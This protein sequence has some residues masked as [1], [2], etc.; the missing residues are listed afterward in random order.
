MRVNEKQKSVQL[1][2]KKTKKIPSSVP[3]AIDSPSLDFNI[4]AIIAAE[5]AIAASAMGTNTNTRRRASP[6]MA[7]GFAWHC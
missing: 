3:R 6:S 7:S 4:G 1:P 5:T 2:A